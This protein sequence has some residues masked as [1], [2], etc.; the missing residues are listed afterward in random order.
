MQREARRLSAGEHAT[1]TTRRSSS[2]TTASRW[3]WPASTTP[4]SR[5]SRRRSPCRISLRGNRLH[6][7]ATAATSSRRG[8]V[9]GELLAVIGQGLPV[10]ADTVASAVDIVVAEHGKPSE[11]YSRHRL[12]ASR[13]PDRPAH[14]QPEAL[15]RRDPQEHDH[16]RHRPGGHRQDL[17][18]GGDGGARAASARAS[19]ASSSR[20][21]RSRRGRAS[22]SCRARSRRRSTPTSARCSTRS[23]T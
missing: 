18:R 22:A 4:T 1:L 13:P 16:L 17:P 5:C 23:T 9:V 20:G 15:R 19:G 10:D 6:L 2:T 11:V 3:R 12:V 21:R 14:Q 7:P 8:T